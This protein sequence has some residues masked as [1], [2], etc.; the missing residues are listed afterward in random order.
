MLR[1]LLCSSGRLHRAGDRAQ[2]E[3]DNNITKEQNELTQPDKWDRPIM[4]DVPSRSA[5]KSGRACGFI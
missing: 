3:L 5:L 1:S 2:R 4:L